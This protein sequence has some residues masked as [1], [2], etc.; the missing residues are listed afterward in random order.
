MPPGSLQLTQNLPLALDTDLPTH[1]GPGSKHSDTHHPP[2]SHLQHE[3][4]LQEPVIPEPLLPVALGLVLQ[5]LLLIVSVL[6]NRTAL[7]I[8]LGRRQGPNPLS[9]PCSLE[10]LWL[11][12]FPYGFGERKKQLSEALLAV[13]TSF[14]RS[15]RRDSLVFASSCHEQAR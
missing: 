3:E 11:L 2:Y 9:R 4:D 7:G 14:C 6:C 5:P 10:P 1:Q 12:A 13:M 15:G 8:F